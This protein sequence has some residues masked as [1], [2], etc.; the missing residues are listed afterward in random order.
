MAAALPADTAREMPTPVAQDQFM[1]LDTK[2]PLWLATP[3]VPAGGYGATIWA[4][5]CDGVDTTP[6]P[7]GPT[8]RMPSSRHRATSSSSSRRPAS[9]D[10]P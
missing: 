1:K 10:S 2:F 7:L 8:S 3:M 5:R 6:W 4:H 9:P